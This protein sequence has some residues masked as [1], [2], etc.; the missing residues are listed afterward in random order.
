MKYCIDIGHN[1]PPLDTGANGILKEDRVNLEVG[2][3]LIVKLNKG[4]DKVTNSLNYLKDLKGITSRSLELQARCDASNGAKVDLFVSI[5]ANAV[6]A[7]NAQG[8]EVWYYSQ[9]GYEMALRI[10]AQIAKLGYV[11]RGPKKIGVDGNN[12]YI[13]KHTVAV[14]V[15]VECFFIDSKH[16]VDLYDLATMSAAIYTAITGRKDIVSAVGVNSAQI[17]EL[18]ALMNKMNIKDMYK[19]SLIEDGIIGPKTIYCL[20][21]LYDL[22]IQLKGAR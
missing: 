12:L 7:H 20:K 10:C 19:N 9:N 15:L 4:G 3:N 21:I 18:Q 14:A 8:V 16:D 2:N 6:E 22:L 17:K 5:H 1:Y 13:I 11:N